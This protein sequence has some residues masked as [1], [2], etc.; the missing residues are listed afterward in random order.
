MPRIITWSISCTPDTP[1]SSVKIASFII[2]NRIR[3]AT[4]PG[5]SLTITGFLFNS[6][7]RSIIVRIV[8]LLVWWVFMTSTN[9][10]TG[11]GF[12]K[13]IPITFSCL[14]VTSAIS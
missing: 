6:I 12:M 9:F 7:E 10:I 2:G 5:E 13:C 8:A 1:S 4:N 14:L 11:T 3:F